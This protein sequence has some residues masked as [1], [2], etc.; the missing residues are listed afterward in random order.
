MK[1]RNP[2]DPD[3]ETGRRR[4]TAMLRKK[5][6]RCKKTPIPGG[7]VCRLHGGA[8]KR[9]KRKAEERLADLIDPKR[10]LREAAR[11]AYSD[12]GQLF[13][14]DGA[15]RPPQEWPPEL[16]ASIASVEMGVGGVEKV[17]LWSKPAA[18]EML[19]K[20]LGLLRDRLEISGDTEVETILARARARA[21]ARDTE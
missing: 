6:V 14:P 20:H 7:F 5:G 13:T 11:L 12:V 16:R 9:A 4:C 15:M 17:R 18:V 1:T 10:L 8:T 21:A 2:I 3:A 19:A